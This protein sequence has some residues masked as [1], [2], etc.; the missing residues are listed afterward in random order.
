MSS[1]TCSPS[2]ISPQPLNG[3]PIKRRSSSKKRKE[4][5]EKTPRTIDVIGNGSQTTIS[6]HIDLLQHLPLHNEMHRQLLQTYRREPGN[7]EG[8]YNEQ[9]ENRAVIKDLGNGYLSIHFYH[10]ITQIELSEF[11]VGKGW[12]TLGLSHDGNKSYEKW[13]NM[14]KRKSKQGV[15]R[16]ASVVRSAERYY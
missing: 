1:V 9:A 14:R 5:D 11:L 12:I 16:Q 8:Q 3:F 4:I 10:D 2:N 7:Y 6:G 13:T 15:A